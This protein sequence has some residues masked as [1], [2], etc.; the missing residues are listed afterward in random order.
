MSSAAFTFSPPTKRSVQMDKKRTILDTAQKRSLAIQMVKALHLNV[1]TRNLETSEEWKV[2]CPFHKDK[3][4]SMFI[5]PEKFVYNCFSC[6]SQGSLASLYYKL[7]SRSLYKDFNIVNDEFTV[8]SFRAEAYEPPDYSKPPKDLYVKSV[9]GNI[10]PVDKS[11]EAIAYLRKRGIPFDIARSMSM[12]FMKEGVINGVL[13]KDGQLYPVW[14]D[15][16]V[17]PIVENGV[18]LAYEGRD[19]TGSQESKVLYSREC[20]VQTLFELEKLKKDEPLYVVEGITKLAVLR[21][22]PYFANSTATFGSG[23]NERQLWL[24][25]QFDNVVIIPDADAAG[26]RSIKRLKENM[27]REFQVLELL[28]WKD[29][30]M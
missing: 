18:I 23:L 12:G 28:R 19:T 16:L 14:R 5:S 6:H 9:V 13:G 3:T 10:V 21:T 24:L 22:D 20:T 29:L 15:R 17:I 2:H 30:K 27:N 8:F 11:S 26:M 25:K 1:K 7:T 4:P